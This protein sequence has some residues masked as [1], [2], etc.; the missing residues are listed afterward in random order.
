WGPRVVDVDL[1]LYD[2][3]HVVEAEPWLEIPHPEM[4]R[5]LFVLVPLRDL[6]PDLRAPDGTPSAPRIAALEATTRDARRPYA[7]S[8]QPTEPDELLR[9]TTRSRNLSL[10]LPVRTAIIP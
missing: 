4:W 8:P 3:R 9:R 10:V 1:L 2:D 6:R 5:R 7:E